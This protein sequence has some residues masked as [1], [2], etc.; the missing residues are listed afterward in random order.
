MKQLFFRYCTSSQKRILSAVL[1]LFGVL[2][3]ST[4]ATIVDF[5]SATSFSTNFTN[6][7][8]NA[9]TGWNASQGRG[10]SGTMFLQATGH[11]ANVYS[12]TNATFSLSAGESLVVSYFF[13]ESYASRSATNN[14]GTYLTTNSSANPL[15]SGTT[16]GVLRTFFYN[17]DPAGTQTNFRYSN[18]G[19]NGSVGTN[20]TG[21]GN[22]F[23]TVNASTWW[24][25]EVT[26]TKSTTTNLWDVTAKFSNWGANGLTYNPSSLITLNNSITNADLYG[27][28]SIYVGFE[29]Y[30]QSRGAT[31]IDTFS[32][33]VI[34]E[35]SAAALLFV[36]L[37]AIGLASRSR[38][39]IRIE[40]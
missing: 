27:A 7:G 40:V 29:S 1:G 9:V 24:Q 23:W 34:P 39:R 8:G 20:F 17:M 21:G 38:K 36:G 11:T 6:V 10:G 22:G 26:Y 14:I 16:S 4:A 15:D 3:C 28:S 13:F 19:G 18:T 37:T 30:Q 12:G 25:I 31:K 32:M 2:S 35:P 5:D 33:D